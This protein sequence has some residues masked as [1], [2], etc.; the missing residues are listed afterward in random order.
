MHSKKRI[1][2]SGLTKLKS[3]TGMANQSLLGHWCKLSLKQALGY[4]VKKL[5]G[6]VSNSRSRPLA[7]AA[8]PFS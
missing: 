2:P 1:K 3:E 5:N 8:I 7:P 6:H 4:V